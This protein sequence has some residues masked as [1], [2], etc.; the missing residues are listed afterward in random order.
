MSLSRVSGNFASMGGPWH[1]MGKAAP[2]A[3]VHQPP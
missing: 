1:G 3:V 2:V